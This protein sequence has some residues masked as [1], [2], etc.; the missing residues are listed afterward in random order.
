MLLLL[1]KALLRRTRGFSKPHKFVLIDSMT[2]VG[3]LRSF[4]VIPNSR[5]VFKKFLDLGR[6]NH[7]YMIPFQLTYRCSTRSSGWHVDRAGTLDHI[8]GGFDHHQHCRLSKTWRSF[9][10]GP[11]TPKIRPRYSTTTTSES[12]DA[13]T[14]GFVVLRAESLGEIIRSYISRICII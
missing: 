11:A 4:A 6:S 14:A 7:C 12:F 5:A 8:S 10:R 3:Y 9:G 2:G 13:S 1:C